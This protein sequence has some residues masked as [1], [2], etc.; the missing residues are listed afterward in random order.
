M[1]TSLF[2][3]A[4]VGPHT[5]HLTKSGVGSMAVKKLLFRAYCM[6]VYACQLRN[7]YTQTGDKLLRITSNNAYRILQDIVYSECRFSSTSS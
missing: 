3:E 2:V 4:H 5:A 7:M 6:P 1:R